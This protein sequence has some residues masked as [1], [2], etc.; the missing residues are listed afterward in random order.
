MHRCRNVKDL[1]FSGEGKSSGLIGSESSDGKWQKMRW[2]K[3]A[4][5]DLKAK[6]FRGKSCTLGGALGVY[7]LEEHNQ[8]V[9]P[10]LSHWH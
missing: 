10:K 9:F 6:K 7:G 3:E 4:G 2:E 5:A 8:F 1:V